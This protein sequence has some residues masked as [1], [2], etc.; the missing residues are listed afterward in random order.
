M[1]QTNRTDAVLDRI[2]AA[3]IHP[4][5]WESCLSGMLDHFTAWGA[6]LFSYNRAH[7]RVIGGYACGEEPPPL[8]TLPANTNTR[9]RA[10]PIAPLVPDGGIVEDTLCWQMPTRASTGF[11]VRVSRHDACDI[12]LAVGCA[13]STH[14]DV[15]RRLRELRALSSHV[16]RSLFSADV[17]RRTLADEGRSDA[18]MIVVNRDGTPVHFN[19]KM[20]RLCDANDGLALTSGGLKLSSAAEQRLLRQ[21]IETQAD[22]REGRRAMTAKRPSGRR[23]YAIFVRQVPE[24]NSVLRAVERQVLVRITDPEKDRHPQPQMLIDLYNLTKSEAMLGAALVRKGNLTCAAAD[25]DIT[26]GSARQYMKRIFS[27]T[28]TSGQ[29]EFVSLVSGLSPI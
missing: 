24:T 21:I 11:G 10:F 2:Y 12:I 23:P 14:P 18:G 1:A 3:G 22:G 19:A 16:R 29:V 26:V 25:C 13:N 15:E 8:H 27:K 5:L 20:E 6:Q 7:D 28:S 9:S 4:D 17:K